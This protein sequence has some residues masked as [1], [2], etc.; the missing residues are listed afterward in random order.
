MDSKDHLRNAFNERKKKHTTVRMIFA[1]TQCEHNTTTLQQSVQ[2]KQ[3][4]PTLTNT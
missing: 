4:K 1:N 3:S 2:S